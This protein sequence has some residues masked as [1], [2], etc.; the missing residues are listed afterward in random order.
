[1]FK[2][3]GTP[4]KPPE[5][6]RGHLLGGIW[7]TGDPVAVTGQ[8]PVGSG[9]LAL[10]SR[11]DRFLVGYDTVGGSWREFPL[12]VAVDRLAR[13]LDPVQEEDAE[14][15]FQGWPEA[16]LDFFE[17]LEQD[18]SKAYW[19]AHRQLYDDAVLGPLTELTEDLSSEFGPVKIFR[20]Y[21]DI[22]FSADKSPYKTEAGAM[23]GSA[24]IRLS[25]AGLAAGN[26]MFHLAA[27]QLARYRY[28]V[29]DDVRGGELASIV[30]ALSGEGVTMI[31]HD[32]L[33]SAPRGYPVDHPR[34]ELLRYK[35]LAAYREWPVEPWLATP[36]AADRVRDFL[37]ATKPL[38]SWLDDNVGDSEAPPARRR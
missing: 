10:A 18:N 9:R 17:D 16:A 13:L 15:S 11:P 6:D 12:T 4:P 14:M 21:R 36:A 29:A 32:K 35:G 28:A 2:G 30:A 1:M 34:V 31:G 23:V 8:S 26:G 19:T 37:A 3:W 20:P 38:D 22:R 33:K 25:A 24:Y 5:G 27:D 7:V